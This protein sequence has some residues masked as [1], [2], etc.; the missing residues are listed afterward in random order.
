MPRKPRVLC[1]LVRAQHTLVGNVDG[2][3]TAPELQLH[4]V[5]LGH[6]S[7]P[8]NG[9]EANVP[10]P[11]LFFGV[12]FC[13]FAPWWLPKG[14]PL[15]PCLSVAQPTLT[16]GEPS[17]ATPACPALLCALCSAAQL[18]QRKREPL[19]NVVVHNVQRFTVCCPPRTLARTPRF[20]QINMHSEANRQHSEANRCL[21]ALQVAPT[22]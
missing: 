11:F 18:F 8:S 3:A 14:R 7:D 15:L 13:I 12:F 22:D 17:N 10:P 16:P 20:S 9:A 1:S 6:T 5:S 19:H 4:T 21:L 2:S